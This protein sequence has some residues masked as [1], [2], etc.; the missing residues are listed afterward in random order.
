MLAL[1]TFYTVGATW[2]CGTEGI[3]PLLIP[4]L[5]SFHKYCNLSPCN[6]AAISQQSVLTQL[7][8]FLPMFLLLLFI[9]AVKFSFFPIAQSENNF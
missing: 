6:I 8:V 9:L 3:L 2:D 1:P 4:H 7:F 5:L